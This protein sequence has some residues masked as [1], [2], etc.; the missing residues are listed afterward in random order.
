[1]SSEY[2]SWLYAIS[3]TSISE[4]YSS[5]LQRCYVY[6][7][8]HLSYVCAIHVCSTHRDQKRMSDSLKLE[9]HV[10]VRNQIWSTARIASSLNR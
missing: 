4:I 9:L 5:F 3:F 10:V 7:C 1:M 8:E 2:K 6:V